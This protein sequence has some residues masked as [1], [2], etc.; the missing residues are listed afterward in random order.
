[1]EEKTKPPEARYPRPGVR[2]SSRSLLL[3]YLRP[4]LLPILIGLAFLAITDAT[5]IAAPVYIQSA[6][7]S[8]RRPTSC[9]SIVGNRGSSGLAPG[10]VLTRQAPNAGQPIRT[11]DF[12]RAAV[13]MVG[14][15]LVTSVFR[16]AWRCVIWPVSLRI[17]R[18]LRRD[19]LL[20]LQSLDP[21]YF[22]HHPVGDLMSRATSD[23]G[24][25]QRFVASG[26]VTLFDI[27]FVIPVTLFLMARMDLE[28]AVITAA[29]ILLGP[30]LSS[31]IMGRLSRAYRRSQDA[32][33]L[34]SARVQEDVTGIRVLKSYAREHLALANFATL[35]QRVCEG[36]LGVSRWQGL[37]G[38]YFQFIPQV[39]MLLLVGLGISW[40][41]PG[42]CTTGELVAF[43]WYL[44]ILSWPTFGVG[45]SMALIRR[46]DSSLERL[47]EVFAVPARRRSAIAGGSDH[48]EGGR[49]LLEISA[50]VDGLRFDARCGGLP[51]RADDGAGE[52]SFRGLTFGWN[53]SPVLDHLDLEIPAGQILGLT[54]PTGSGKSTLLSLVVG[55]AEPPEKTVFLDQKDVREIAPGRLRRFVA[56]VEQAPYLFSRTL[57][58]NVAFARPDATP[59]EV[60]EASLIAGLAPDLSRFDSGLDTLVG[61][62]GIRLSGGQKLRVA[63]ARAV[64]ARPR[65]LLLDDVFSAVDSETEE[66]VFGS[67]LASMAGRTVVVVSHRVSVLRRCDRIAVLENGRISECAPHQELL[68]RRGFYA[69]TFS[70]QELFETRQGWGRSG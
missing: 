58:E 16:M 5:Q 23:V 45:W 6:I 8:L 66:T 15:T 28:I 20:H 64:L 42:R 35:N 62:R 9:P 55:L 44:G 39:S 26:T 13:I 59:Q 24:V 61:D 22:H 48:A 53:G 57:R 30:F 10:G 37:I 11:G 4:H 43:Q 32:L 12:V 50:S 47:V 14:L 70:F 65:V 67:L 36:L 29:P 52:L 25:V 41:F 54:G 31:I 33:G 7:D 68:D 19:L 21:S 56:L 60:S 27:L 38:P 18:E 63:I 40:A 49:S 3:A 69:R 2:V 17:E 34:L 51:A 46:L 1:M